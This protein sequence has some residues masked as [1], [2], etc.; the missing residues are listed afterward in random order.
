M[1]G[2]L[3]DGVEGLDYCTELFAAALEE[4]FADE[5]GPLEVLGFFCLRRLTAH[6]LPD[7]Q[8][9]VLFPQR[10]QLAL[11]LHRLQPK[12]LYL[13]LKF[14]QL[15]L[16]LEVCALNLKTGLIVTLVISFCPLHNTFS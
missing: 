2:L 3:V 6:L 13:C 4:F 10:A 1:A 11:L 8:L 12:L 7:S 15:C 14:L 5:L 9:L 16:A